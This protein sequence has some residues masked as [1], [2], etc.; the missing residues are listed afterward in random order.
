MEGVVDQ[1]QG[2]LGLIDDVVGLFED[3]RDN[4]GMHDES[5]NNIESHKG[6]MKANKKANH[7]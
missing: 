6:K 4:D 1:L 7:S 3:W 5:Q 2:C